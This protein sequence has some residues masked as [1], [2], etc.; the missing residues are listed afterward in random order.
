MGT[1]MILKISLGIFFARIVVKRWHLWTIRTAVAL[2]VTSST[3]G[4]F[5]CLFRCGPNL[6][7][8]VY[9]QLAFECTPRKLD[10]FIAYQQ[11]SITTSTDIVF[12]LLPLFIL[13][14]AN[15]DT[16]SKISVGFILSLAAL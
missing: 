8:Y 3:A 9:R 6:N 1:V 15:M 12:A 13:W 14:N 10:L 7:L 5:Y 4:F 11:A 2:N 16:R